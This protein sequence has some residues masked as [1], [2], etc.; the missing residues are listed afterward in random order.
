MSKWMIA[1]GFSA[2]LLGG[3]AVTPSEGDPTGVAH[4]ALY[5]EDTT[6]LPDRTGTS[7]TILQCNGMANPFGT[8]SDSRCSECVYGNVRAPGDGEYADCDP[9]EPRPRPRY[10]TR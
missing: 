4:S 8:C 9:H 6:L 2:A 7:C 1:W 5:E 3:C 10:P